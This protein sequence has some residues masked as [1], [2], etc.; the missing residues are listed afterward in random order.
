MRPALIC[1]KHKGVY[2]VANVKAIRETVAGVAVD[3]EGMRHVF[4]YPAAEAGHKGV[5]GLAT[6]GPAD[7]AQIGPAVNGTIY[8]VVKVIDASA[9]AMERLSKIQW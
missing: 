8:D 3:V 2:L 4:Y 1:D 9:E 5:Y 7:G 6:I